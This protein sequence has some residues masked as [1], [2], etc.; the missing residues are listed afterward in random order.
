MSIVG[1]YRQ[2]GADAS[3][4]AVGQAM[5]REVVD[6]R[7]VGQELEVDAILTG[8]DRKPVGEVHQPEA[9]RED[10]ANVVAVQHPGKFGAQAEAAAQA[11]RRKRVAVLGD[12][13]VQERARLCAP[14]R[15][16][17]S[18]AYPRLLCEVLGLLR[19]LR[20]A[21]ATGGFAVAE[22]VPQRQFCGKFWKEVRR[23]AAQANART[24]LVE[25][26]VLGQAE[27]ARRV[28]VA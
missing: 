22:L 26:G 11:E 2:V 19:P 10:L 20:K 4:A 17:P 28:V 18:Q 25:R 1:G 24:R 7:V 5:V 13:R 3:E 14:E 6:P 8:P 15:V 23:H 16:D 12:A 9:S 27:A 21:V